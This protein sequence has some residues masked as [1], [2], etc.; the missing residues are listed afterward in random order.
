MHRV[1]VGDIVLAG[2]SD[3]KHLAVDRRNLVDC[4]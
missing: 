1:A 4:R 2:G 3:L